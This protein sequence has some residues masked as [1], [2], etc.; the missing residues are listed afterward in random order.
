[1][2]FDP[3]PLF[4]TLPFSTTGLGGRRM[5]ML[6]NHLGL[7]GKVYPIILPEKLMDPSRSTSL[8][9]A[10]SAIMSVSIARVQEVCLGN[11]YFVLY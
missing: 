11:V 7:F 4:V 1:M 3:A 6:Q 5:R 8:K 2:K 9:D 10:T